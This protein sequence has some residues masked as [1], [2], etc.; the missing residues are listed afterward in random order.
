MKLDIVNIGEP[1]NDRDLK[2][3]LNSKN[4]LEIHIPLKSIGFAGSYIDIIHDYLLVSYC[5]ERIAFFVKTEKGERITKD[6]YYT[7]FCITCKIQDAESLFD[8]LKS[9]APFFNEDLEGIPKETMVAFSEDLDKYEESLYKKSFIFPELVNDYWAN[10]VNGAYWE[11]ASEYYES[12]KTFLN[13][14]YRKYPEQRFGFWKNAPSKSYK[15]TVYFS[16]ENWIVP[17]EVDII[18]ALKVY[19]G[20]ETDLVIEKAEILSFKQAH[21]VLNSS[22]AVWFHDFKSLEK[23]ISCVYK[24]LL[25]RSK[26]ISPDDSPK[27]CASS[28]MTFFPEN[29]PLRRKRRRLESLKISPL[30]AGKFTYYLSEFGDLIIIEFMKFRHVFFSRN[31]V[32][33]EIL[34]ELY[35]Q[36]NPV[37]S[38][39]QS[40]I[41]QSCTGNCNWKVLNDDLFEELCYDIIYLHPK[42]D[43]STIQKMGK[44]TSRDGGRDIV[45][46]TKAT[47]T[48]EAQLYIFQ[49]KFSKGAGS[50]SASKVP[51]AGNVIMQY[52]ASGYG[53]F[54]PLVID[55]TLYDMLDGFERNAKIDT[56]IRWSKYEL[57]R[58]LNRNG[59]LKKKY[60]GDEI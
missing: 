15:E 60:F 2:K 1:I 22:V 38:K 14:I 36:I 30:E 16:T 56:S 31:T 41:G 8:F 51:N 18:S 28:Q 48:S 3:L 50:L 42:F 24:A 34:K 17:P 7:V 20:L 59:H 4:T 10:L 53:V 55:S 43:S 21:V 47:P 49:C 32:S 23:S 35:E 25:P 40:L 29:K 6:R 39:I 13:R 19:S 58:F 46:K 26:E 5:S 11:I 52:G 45:V 27:S 33:F 12:E 44:S 37:Y 57:E 54:T 9:I